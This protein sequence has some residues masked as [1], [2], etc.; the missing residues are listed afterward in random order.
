MK[1]LGAEGSGAAPS[2]GAVPPPPRPA[3]SGVQAADEAREAGNALFRE[4][5]FHGALEQ[6]NKAAALDPTNVPTLT[7]A[8]RTLYLL[9]RYAESEE[10]ASKVRSLPASTLSDQKPAWLDPFTAW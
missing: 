1:A 6:Y 8:S 7:N 9:H 5:N 2:G 10:A 3:S 4:S